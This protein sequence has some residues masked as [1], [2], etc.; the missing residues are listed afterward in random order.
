MCRC[1]AP[2]PLIAGHPFGKQTLL[3]FGK[4]ISEEADAPVQPCRGGSFLGSCLCLV[5][6]VLVGELSLNKAASS[7]LTG[8]QSEAF[9]RSQPWP[10]GGVLDCQSVG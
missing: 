7:G 6:E 3:D 9:R 2:P 5:E 10:S 1:P 8:Q 4:N